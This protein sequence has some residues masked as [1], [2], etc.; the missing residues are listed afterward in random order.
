MGGLKVTPV[1]GSDLHQDTLKSISG[2][3]QK[4]TD[5][6]H[7]PNIE[8]ASAGGLFYSERRSLIFL[9]SHSYWRGQSALSVGSASL[10]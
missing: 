7:L 1:G 9:D 4:A 6:D 5:L 2:G 8:A 3:L 10:R